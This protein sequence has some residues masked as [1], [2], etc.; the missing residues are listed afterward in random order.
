MRFDIDIYADNLMLPEE[1]MK[2]KRIAPEIIQRVVRLR[3]LYNYMLRHPLKKDKEYTDYIRSVYTNND[4]KQLSLRKAYE[5]IEIIHAV[6]GN[7]Q[8]CT[9]EWHRWRFNN[10]I[11][12]GYAIAVRKED[13]AAI[14]KLSQQYGKYNQLDKNDEVDRGSADMPHIVFTFDVSSMGFKPIK[15]VYALIDK[16]NA[17]FAGKGYERITADE[18]AIVI[19][20][21]E[22]KSRKDESATAISE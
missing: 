7:L 8:M 9:K 21:D 6:I 18:D 17:Q 2:A 15:N 1:E 20:E 12:E 4:G 5:D 11:M 14:A 10:M 13:A 22:V 3:D 16:L 19:D